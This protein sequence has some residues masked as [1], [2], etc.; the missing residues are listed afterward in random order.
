MFTFFNHNFRDF[1]SF[2]ENLIPSKSALF[3]MHNNVGQNS[4][5][6]KTQTEM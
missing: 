3:Y 5:V 1:S 2:D 4:W 6:L